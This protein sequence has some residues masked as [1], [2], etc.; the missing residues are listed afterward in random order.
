MEDVRAQFE[1]RKSEI[2]EY[3]RL[4]GHLREPDARIY[5]PS[6]EDGPYIDIGSGVQKT[7]KASVF[8]LLYNNVEA[9]VRNCFLSVYQR[10]DAERLGYRDASTALKAIWLEERCADVK[11]PEAAWTSY[12]KKA[13][14][15]VSAAVN[16]APLD[17]SKMSMRWQGNLDAERVRSLCREHKVRLSV[18]PSARG[19]AELGVIKDKRNDLAH[20]NRSFDECGREYDVSDLARIDAEAN[21]FLSSLISCIEGFIQRAGYRAGYSGSE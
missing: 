9:T 16:N 5:A 21:T 8:L 6:S 10:I 19:G 2:E 3:L 15:M 7:L 4:L 12:R 1:E 20:G 13:E 11:G 14:E 18:P 17:M